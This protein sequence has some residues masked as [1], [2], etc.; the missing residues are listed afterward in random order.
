MRIVLDTNVLVAGLLNPEGNPGRVVDLYLAGEVALLVDDRILAEYRAVL[1]RRKFSFDTE[2]VSD[3]L[4]Q[5]EAE[6][7]RISA[8]PL[9]I[10]LPDPE[11]LRFLEVAVAG[12]AESLVTGN[13]RH[14]KKGIH[15]IPTESPAGFIRKWNRAGAS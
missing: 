11:D 1:H 2:D 13:A 14:F 6:S 12:G 10:D 3:L 5:I 8:P 9:G 15:P 4:D 7:I